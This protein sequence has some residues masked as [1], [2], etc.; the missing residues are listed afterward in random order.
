MN[1]KKIFAK[2]DELSV[3]EFLKDSSRFKLVNLVAKLDDESRKELRKWLF[4]IH[5]NEWTDCNG[6]YLSV[7]LVTEMVGLSRKALYSVINGAHGIQRQTIIRLAVG[8]CFSPVQLWLLSLLNF[9]IFESTEDKVVLVGLE[10]GIYEL[11]KLDEY[12]AC[13]IANPSYHFATPEEEELDMKHFLHGSEGNP[14]TRH[15]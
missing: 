7:D 2:Y 3:K 12:I 11:D 5:K 8:Y 4:D 1:A 15:R 9:M 13:N 6:Q 10:T 14:N